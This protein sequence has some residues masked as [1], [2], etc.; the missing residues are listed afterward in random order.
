MEESLWIPGCSGFPLPSPGRSQQAWKEENLGRNSQEACPPQGLKEELLW[1]TTPTPCRARQTEVTNETGLTGAQEGWKPGKAS[2]RR[3]R[4]QPRWVARAVQVEKGEQPQ[5][6]ETAYAKVPQVSGEP[7]SQLG[8]ERPGAAELGKL[9]VQGEA[10][11]PG[12]AGSE[13][14]GRRGQRE[15]GRQGGGAALSR[16]E[17]MTRDISECCSWSVRSIPAAFSR[18]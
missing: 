17:V 13:A 12:P 1:N 14:L 5:G 3:W 6:R 16:F 11:G 9:H 18:A 2:W 15:G 4:H 7:R 10:E 8:L